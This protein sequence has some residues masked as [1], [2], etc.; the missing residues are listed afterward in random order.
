MASSNEGG[1]KPSFKFV[2]EFARGPEL[3]KFTCTH[4]GR[5]FSKEGD[6]MPNDWEKGN[7]VL[8]DCTNCG[9][10]NR[11]YV[12]DVLPPAAYRKKSSF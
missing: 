4:C 6:K 11:F 2:F 1:G 5:S 3:Y 9:K 10:Q 12:A 8:V 7:I